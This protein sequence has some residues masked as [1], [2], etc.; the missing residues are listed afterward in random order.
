MHVCCIGSIV[1]YCYIAFLH[2]PSN[3]YSRRS[4]SATMAALFL[5]T[6]ASMGSPDCATPMGSAAFHQIS[7]LP[8]KTGGTNSSRE[9][10]GI[11]WE[12]LDGYFSRTKSLGD[13][14]LHSF[15]RILRAH[16]NFPES[17]DQ[18]R[19]VAPSMIDFDFCNLCTFHQITGP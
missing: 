2:G 4:K 16:V 19:S 12:T 8:I 7:G 14:S 1:F 18:P 6:T 15:L 5:A 9:C 10:H 17:E 3:C 11:S 13:L